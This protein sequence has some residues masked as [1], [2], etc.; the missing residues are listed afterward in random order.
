[1]TARE[2]REK[3]L[4]MSRLS[5]ADQAEFALHL[6]FR[7]EQDLESLDADVRYLIEHLFH[8]DTI[9]MS[10]KV[11][12]QINGLKKQKAVTQAFLVELGGPRLA[13]PIVRKSRDEEVA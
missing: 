4:R 5:P 11:R 1:M 13:D 12:R 10:W 8:S 3:K 2:V 6:M 9:R 7:C